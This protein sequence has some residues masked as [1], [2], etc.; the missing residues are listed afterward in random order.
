ME[1]NQ[2]YDPIRA[3]QTSW[4][5]IRQSPLPLIIGG[6]V[7]VITDGNGGGGG[8]NFG[9]IF[10]GRGGARDP[11]WDV[12]APMLIGVIG[13]ACCLGIAFFV[14][15]SW[16]R[17]GFANSVEE[18]LRTGQGDVGRVFEGKGRIVSMLLAR[19]LAGL[20]LVVA[21]LP[22]LLVV[23]VAAMATAGFDQ[24][25]EI[26]FAILVAGAIVYLPVWVYVRLGLLLVPQAVALEGLQPVDSLRRSWSLVSGHRWMLLWYSILTWIWYA[27]GFCACCVGIFLT[28]TMTEAAK[29][30][31]YL[32]LTRGGERK[33]WWIETGS[34]PTSSDPGWGS[35]TQL[36]EKPVGWGAPPPP[37]PPPPT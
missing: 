30:E 13:F 21:A 20:I 36:P 23:L 10:D 19:L 29:T 18:V 1:F 25:W 8:G 5:L 11:D 37:P 6:V 32:A 22:Y 12:I 26:G 9:N 2:A 33:D 7:L 24:N 4:Q 3:L 16:V 35:P 14:I 34:A 27:I 15:S 28:G 31:S 17:I